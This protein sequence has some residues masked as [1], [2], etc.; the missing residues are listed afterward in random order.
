MTHTFSRKNCINSY[1]GTTKEIVI[2]EGAEEMKAAANRGDYDLP[3]PDLSSEKIII[4]SLNL[5]FF[6]VLSFNYLLQKCH[7]YHFQPF[8]QEICSMFVHALHISSEAL[9][10]SSENLCAH[11]QPDC[12]LFP[13]LLKMLFY[14]FLSF[15]LC[16]RC[17]ELIACCQCQ[18]FV[19]GNGSELTS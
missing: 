1:T 10:I 12:L 19:E 18:C 6:Q 9:R 15:P 14:I 5:T 2:Y 17:W 7:I 8:Y 16:P 11:S 3:K 4:W 13:S